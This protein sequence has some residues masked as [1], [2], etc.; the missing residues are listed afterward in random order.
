MRSVNAP[1]NYILFFLSAAFVSALI[2][3]TY[4][5]TE[6]T[7]TFT[8]HLLFH[9]D[10]VLN[11]PTGGFSL[12]KDKIQWRSLNSLFNVFPLCSNVADPLSCMFL[13]ILDLTST[14]FADIGSVSCCGFWQ[15]YSTVTVVVV[16]AVFWSIGHIPH[17][18]V[19]RRTGATELC[20][21]NVSDESWLLK[22]ISHLKDVI[23]W[24]ALH[25]PFMC[26]LL[27]LACL[28]LPLCRA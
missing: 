23:T 10:T 12:W 11:K 5:P 22:G 2:Q 25:L 21:V 26:P 8:F 20:S 17:H 13:F 16:S 19:H 28:S 14:E 24:I 18:T 7:G 15:V 3:L 27:F 1:K 9:P 4:V 6:P